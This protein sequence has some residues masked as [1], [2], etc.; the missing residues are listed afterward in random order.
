MPVTALTQ[1]TVSNHFFWPQIIFLI[2]KV[3]QAL[4][5]FSA[6]M[7]RV[8]P[9]AKAVDDL[10]LEAHDFSVNDADFRETLRQEGIEVQNDRLRLLVPGTGRDPAEPG[11]FALSV[12]AVYA[13]PGLLDL[14]EIKLAD[15]YGRMTAEG[16]ILDGEWLVTHCI[17]YRWHGSQRV[18]CLWWRRTV[19]IQ[20]SDL[21]VVELGDPIPLQ[22]LASLDDI[23]QVHDFDISNLAEVSSHCLR[24]SPL[25]LEK[26]LGSFSRLELVHLRCC[27]RECWLAVD[28][29][30]R[31]HG[32]PDIDDQVRDLCMK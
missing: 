32:V 30:E 18:N 31:R 17:V 3:P 19:P 1:N 12:A 11:R 24:V 6:K 7:Q 29:W 5:V 16:S 27:S 26:T 13:A 14:S 21:G 15:V 2:N 9:V 25:I 8:V 23:K 20:F 28:E 4:E 10:V 22:Y